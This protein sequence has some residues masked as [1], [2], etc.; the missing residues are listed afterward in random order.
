MVNYFE[1]VQVRY[2]QVGD[3]NVGNVFVDLQEVIEV[4]GCDMQFEWKFLVVDGGLV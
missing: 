2:Y 1:V 4:V 3:Q